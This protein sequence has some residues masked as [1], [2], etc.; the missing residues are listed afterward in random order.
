MKGASMKRVTAK[1]LSG[2]SAGGMERLVLG[3]WS[4][5]GVR[6]TALGWV[7]MV[8]FA[9]RFSGCG[10]GTTAAEAIAAAVSRGS[11]TSFIVMFDENPQSSSILVFFG[12]RWRSR[13]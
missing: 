4:R 10:G 7:W 13:T 3:F 2:K 11:K 8:G 5:D 9:I 6:V 12:C 1:A